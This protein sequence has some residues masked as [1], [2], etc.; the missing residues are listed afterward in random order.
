MKCDLRRNAHGNGAHIRYGVQKGSFVKGENSSKV[1]YDERRIVGE[2]LLTLWVAH[3][4]GICLLWRPNSIVVLPHIIK[5]CENDSS[6]F[7]VFQI[8]DENRFL[9]KLCWQTNRR[10]QNSLFKFF[11]WWVLKREMKSLWNKPREQSTR[12]CSDT[13]SDLL[14]FKK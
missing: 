13:V 8:I 3:F 12:Y 6:Y 10:I 11:F 14:C 1:S 5:A 9:K 7:F 2:N 4:V